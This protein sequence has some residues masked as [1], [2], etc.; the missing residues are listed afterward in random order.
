MIK[1]II[2]Y[3]ALISLFR[4]FSPSLT[5]AQ[6]A[7]ANSRSKSTVSIR[8]IDFNNFSY[9]ASLFNSK[10]GI[11]KT[12][13]V[14][15]TNGENSS[16]GKSELSASKIYI[17][18]LAGIANE[19]AMVNIGCNLG[20]TGVN[21]EEIYATIYFYKMQNGQLRLLGSEP[22]FEQRVN[23]YTRY[24]SKGTEERF[25]MIMPMIEKGLLT[26]KNVTRTG[27]EHNP[28]SKFG[29]KLQYRWNGKTFV[30]AGRPERWR[31]ADFDCE[32][33]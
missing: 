30:L 22:S 4:L 20:E 29:A 2:F 10:C 11:R 21:R 8:K 6:D 28:D 14:R 32:Q 12:N 16:Y 26:Y 31:C 9:P 18:N 7:N 19:I 17:G 33:R 25:D 1:Q 24:Y 27:P 3:F 5:Q 15:I 23:D 13:S